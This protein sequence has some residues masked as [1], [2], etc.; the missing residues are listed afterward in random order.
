MPKQDT[1]FFLSD[2][3]PEVGTEDEGKALYIRLTGNER[4]RFLALVEASG[5]SDVR[6]RIATV[7]LHVAKAGL[8]AIEKMVADRANATKQVK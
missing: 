1:P 5:R 3:K 8:T 6:G 2:E 4:T 7:G